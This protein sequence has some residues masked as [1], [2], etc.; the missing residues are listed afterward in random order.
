MI[1]LL[2][3]FC[4]RLIIGWLIVDPEIADWEGAATSAAG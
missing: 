3:C 4:G 1:Q 2:G